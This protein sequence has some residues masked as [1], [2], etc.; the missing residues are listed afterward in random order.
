M[1]QFIEVASCCMKHVS[2]FIKFVLGI[3]SINV[4]ASTVFEAI[5]LVLMM[6]WIYNVSYSDGLR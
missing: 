1:N 3:E 2:N 4:F 6:D 5:M